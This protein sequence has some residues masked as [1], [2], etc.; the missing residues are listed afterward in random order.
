MARG[1]LVL[2]VLTVAF[3]LG[4]AVVTARVLAWPAEAALPPPDPA[5]GH[6]FQSVLAQLLLRE[7]GLSSR[8]DPLTLTAADLNAF[9]AGHM[10]VR[11]LPVWPVSARLDSGQLS[12]GGATTIGKLLRQG[13]GIEGDWAIL[14]RLGEYPLWVATT[15]EIVVNE[16]RAEFRAHGATIGR[17]GVPV[18]LLWRLLGE[19]PRA[20]T[21]RMPRV[22]ERVGIEP[23]RVVVHTRRVRPGG[24][25]PSLGPSARVRAAAAVLTQPDETHP[26]G[27][28]HLL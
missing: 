6:R 23:G 26:K 9:L 16:G 12:L 13:L 20:L 15:G 17:Q 22:V 2:A 10:A 8:D 1:R 5:A 14:G 3:A 24:R 21:W 28:Q 27:R 18:A 19:R 11:D 7:G 25:T 4:A